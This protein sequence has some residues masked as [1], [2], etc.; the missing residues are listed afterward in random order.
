MAVELVSAVALRSWFAVLS[1]QEKEKNDLIDNILKTVEAYES[2]I[3]YLK[4]EVD[5]EKNS[6]ITFQEKLETLTRQKVGLENTL[7]QN[8]FVVVLVDGDGAIFQDD[9]L[10]RPKEGANEASRRIV[11]AVKESLRDDPLEQED[12]TILVRIFANLND[13]GK[14]LHLS[15]IIPQR[16]DLITFAE[17]LTTSRGEFDFINVGPGK[18]NADSKMRKMLDHFYRNVQCKK[19]FFAGCHDNGYLHDLQQYTN[20]AHDDAHRIVLVET[21][22]AQPSFR[23]LLPFPIV[24]FDNVFRSTSLRLG[25]SLPSPGCAGHSPPRPIPVSP[26]D[27]EP[28]SPASI[29]E[30]TTSPRNASPSTE[31][32][33]ITNPTTGPASSMV[34]S[35]NGG[36]SVRYSLTYATAGGSENH[37]N[38]SLKTDTSKTARSIEYN[39]NSQ[40]LDPPNKRPQDLAVWESY[41]DKLARVQEGSQRRGFCN[42]EYLA[43]GCTRRSTCRMEHDAVLDERELLVQRYKART[44]VCLTGPSCSEWDCFF[45]HHC[46][47]ENCPRPNCKFDVH[48]DESEREV[49]ER[50]TEGKSAPDILRGA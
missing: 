16:T 29:I 2:Q 3:R 17:H 26:V 37:H 12:I 42:W 44:G 48:L 9:L 19:I 21:T 31:P 49:W 41:H 8:A 20:N 46:P 4:L 38:I 5:H 24:R 27:E 14:T 36:K 11:Q 15:N 45:S 34:M 35:G 23:S 33:E 32:P 39:R 30:Q 47:F 18:E 50:W 13:L 25:D 1:A 43:G 7:A 28:T 10:A 22:P 40:R 6:R